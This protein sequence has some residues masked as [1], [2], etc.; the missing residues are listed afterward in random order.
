MSATVEL[1]AR[2]SVPGRP[3]PSR[4]QPPPSGRHAIRRARLLRRLDGSGGSKVVMVTAPAGYGK[5]TLLAQWAEA[6]PRPVAWLQLERDDDDPV[7]LTRDVA[8]ALSQVGR[9]DPS[10]FDSLR[11]D[12]GALA[13]VALPRL[14]AA[15]REMPPFV[16]VFDDAHVLRTAPAQDV[17]RT[18]VEH[19]P[20]HS[21][22]VVSARSQPAIPLARLRASGLL[23][24]ID[25]RELALTKGE[26]MKLLAAAVPGI[27]P[28]VATTVAERCEGWAAAL[29]LASI[30]LRHDPDDSRYA[31]DLT[32]ADYLNEEV[33]G[34]ASRDDRAFLTRSSILPTLNGSLCDA[35]LERD[36]S[37]GRLRR[38]ADQ[39][40]LVRPLDHRGERYRIHG[41]FKETL[42]SNIEHSSELPDLHARAAVWFAGHG[43]V[44]Q[45]IAHALDAG[46]AQLAADYAWRITPEWLSEGRSGEL[47]GIVARFPASA[48]TDHPELDAMLALC[49]INV[50]DGEAA[51]IHTESAA[52]SERRVLSDG[53]PLAGM[54]HMLQAVI[55]RD[56]ARRLG[57]AASRA[58][59][60]L[61]APSPYGTIPM[62]LE[63]A[64][65]HIT[66]GGDA[67]AE[68]LAA[69]ERFAADCS[70]TMQTLCLAQLALIDVER[71]DWPAA[72]HR[73]RRARAVQ[74]VHGFEEYAT[75]HIVFAMSALVAAQAGDASMARSEAARAHRLVSSQHHLSPWLA[76]QTLIVLA[77]TEAD[78]GDAAAARRSLKRAK[79][80]VLLVPDAPALRTHFDEASARVEA[81]EVEP[82]EVRTDLTTAEMRVLEQLP[83]YH[84]LREIGD[85]LGVSLNT[86]KSQVGAIYRKLGVSSRSEAV[87]AARQL[88]LLAP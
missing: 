62:Y 26:S 19:L 15:L 10:I 5:T 56:G 75:Q 14:A 78:L 27:S 22:L 41:L 87:V 85:E 44:A 74:R 59:E 8:F 80:L 60:L 13:S 65:R 79:A 4:L 18:V 42:S 37:T 63:G 2:L 6:D 25:S 84:V 11:G 72:A 33:L 88:G 45:A 67:A 71:G 55:G 50:G 81:L 20:E 39:N 9:F 21:L 48:R 3:N 54:V 73:L 49:A 24:E 16:L 69:A 77:R 1:D 28:A 51:L 17:L 66:G 70:P 76:A 47:A 36:D 38:L 43:D 12:R 31:A 58:L 86:V 32:I 40:L 7:R 83:S 57:E 53:T 30:A 68:Q 52:R 46:D 29:Y 61:P 82:Q 23:D 35:V 34:R 64:A